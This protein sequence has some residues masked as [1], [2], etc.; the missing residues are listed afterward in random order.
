MQAATGIKLSVLNLCIVALAGCSSS[1]SEPAPALSWTACSDDAQFECA[2]LDVPRDYQQPDAGNIQLAL[3]RKPAPAETRRGALLVNIGGQDAA[4]K[5][6]DFLFNDSLAPAALF[7]EYDVVGF[8]PRGTGG[9]TPVSCNEFFPEFTNPY[10]TSDEAIQQIVTARSQFASDCSEKVGDYLQLLGSQ[11][12]VN[13][14]EE[15][16]KAMGDEKLNYFGA[17]FGTRAGALYLQSFP[18]NSGAFVLDASVPPDS[19][20]LSTLSLQLSQVQ[21]NLETLFSDCA[22]IDP[23]CNPEELLRSAEARF[24]SLVAENEIPEANLLFEI[25][26][27]SAEDLEFGDLVLGPLVV[28][29]QD[30]DLAAFEN[31]LTALF[32]SF[33]EGDNEE[34]GDDDGEENFARTA[35]VFCAD[36]AARPDANSLISTL[37]ELN[38]VSDLFAE[39]FL[40]DIPPFCIGWPEALNPLEPITTNTAPRALIIG[41]AS[42]IF[43]PIQGSRDLATSIGAHII[44]SAHTGHTT[45]YNRGNTCVDAAVTDYLM[46]GNIP[47]I[48]ECPAE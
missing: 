19:S 47:S 29:L 37:A 6:A 11:E 4:S 46:S 48:S 2:T 14:M 45:V 27:L 43:S 15:I 9:S 36:D 3:R 10:P 22:R 41:G 33:D 7:E 34:E 24:N 20:L 23:D 26:F 17:S 39:F 44:E 25:L 16:R 21:A 5:D 38:Q 40:A 31:S 28:Y 8:D 30:L 35:A 1:D 32:N 42:D 13:D 18:E 12:V